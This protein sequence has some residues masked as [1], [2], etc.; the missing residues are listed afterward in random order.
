MISRV[1]VVG[2]LGLAAVVCP[3]PCPAQ[4]PYGS[5][6]QA[7]GARPRGLPV[8]ISALPAAVRNDVAKIVQHPTLTSHGPAEELPV[9]IYAWLLDHPD[10]AAVAWQR[11]GIPCSEIKNLGQGRFGW[12]DGQGSQITWQAVWKSETERVW[13]A[14]GQAK[15][16]PMAPAVPLRAVAV[17]RHPRRLT[18]H[19]K[20][21][22][23]HE[24][25]VYAQTDSKAAAL[26][27]RLLG[28]TA[29]RL[30]DQAASQL[31]LFFSGLTRYFERYP[32]D[33]Q[34]LLGDR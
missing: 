32:E 10:R 21:V 5:F 12:T 34:P 24:V 25:D 27:T 31:L 14:E 9:G 33:I 20:T 7:I 26:M 1:L 3:R 17:L 19:G 29:P 8:P 28:P 18:S 23:A 22:V 13:F 15:L 4:T 16:G 2:T 30:A 11:L 6:A